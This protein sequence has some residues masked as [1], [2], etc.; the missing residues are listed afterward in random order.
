[1]ARQK[2][3]FQEIQVDIHGMSHDGR[4]VA[5]IEGKTA[6]IHG[7][8]P[9]ETVLCK[10]TKF[11]NR[12][13][14]GNVLS[15]ITKAPERETP[16][17][18]HFG[19]C[20]GCRLQHVGDA[21][22]LHFKEKSLLEQLTHFG[23]VEPVS[24][25][26][27]I[28]GTP[29]GYRRKARLGV[30]FVQKKAKLMVGFRELAS[31]YLTDV[32]QC[33]VLHPSVGQHIKALAETIRRLSQYEHIP[34]V[35]VA[36]GDETTALILRHMT[37]LSE[38]DIQILIEFAK[39]HQ[40]HFYLQPNPPEK[41]QKIWPKESEHILTY[42]L[43]DY[44]IKMQFHPLSFTQVNSEINRLMI[45]Q[46]L[47]L[48]NPQPTDTILD[49]FCGL[50]NFTLPIARF[51]NEVIGIEGSAEMVTAATHNAAL[52]NINNALF[53]SANLMQPNRDAP[54]MQ[55]TYHKIL[56]DP[57]RTGAKE[58]IAHFPSFA[59]QSVVYVSCNPATLARDAHEL[60][61]TQGFS[62]EKV[63]LINMFPHTSHVEAIALFVK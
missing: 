43:P 56:L 37:A 57:P 19:V 11:H 62:L 8:L 41:I 12:Y 63:G 58:I 51:A 59:A 61:H 25:L 29:W 23:K 21:A 47:V 38:N 28:T 10:M 27:P 2:K 54:W 53:Y 39:V 6:F 9:G 20:G 26:P 34:Q 60:V 1:M 7:G 13:Y 4:G 24:I 14:E 35:E 32:E 48:L 50:G 49:L 52:N 31:N 55:R 44:Q 45:K 15:V 36:I 33:P 18:A 17:C 22:Q 46:A 16:A 42:A 40:L 30:R 3:R 5:T